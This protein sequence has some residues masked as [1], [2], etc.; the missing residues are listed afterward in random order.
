MSYKKYFPLR[1]MVIHEFNLAIKQTNYK[2]M[3]YILSIV[4]ISISFFVS[5]Q[6]SLS[7]E[8][9]VFKSLF[10]K[11]IEGQYR[12]SVKGM[13][14]FESKT[15]VKSTFSF[16]EDS[17][18][19]NIVL[20]PDSIYDVSFKNYILKKEDLHLEYRTY[21]MANALY[22]NLGGTKYQL[23]LIDGACDNVINGLEYEYKTTPGKELLILNFTDKVGLFVDRSYKDPELFIQKGSTLVFTIDLKNHLHKS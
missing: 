22:I 3:K 18:N 4:L 16:S 5:A 13:L 19:L 17:V 7:K 11:N 15:G 20:D 10:Q 12:G 8:G 21:A 14:A 6:S 1:K 23:S 2:H 9:H